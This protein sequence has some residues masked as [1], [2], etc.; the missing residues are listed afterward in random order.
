MDQVVERLLARK[1]P[2]QPL[3]VGISGIDASG[4]TRFSA[5]LATA[6]QEIGLPAQ[7]VHLDDYH[8][9]RAV[10]S[11]CEASPPA[12]YYRHTFDWPR[13]TELLSRMQ[14]GS[15]RCR[16]TV[17]DLVSDRYDQ[18][19]E[20]AVD[21]DTMVLVEGVFLFQPG[22]LPD[23]DFRVWLE[24]SRES[25]LRRVVER[26]RHLFGSPDQIMERYLSK[27]LPGQEL[28]RLECRPAEQADLVLQNDDPLQ[29]LYHWRPQS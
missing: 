29:P 28:H 17:L 8:L 22:L 25:S 7:V 1:R 20:Y 19:R 5:E 18:E 27:Y 3:L 21:L 9:P 14:R 10:R 6:L 26:D 23:W 24:V 12:C 4:K 15:M 16:Q 11:S 13:L 2:G